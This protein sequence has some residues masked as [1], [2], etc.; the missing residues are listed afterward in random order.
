MVTSVDGLNW[1]KQTAP[2]PYMIYDVTWANNQFVAVGAG[3]MI[4]TS[5]DGVSRSET[6]YGYDTFYG[7]TAKDGVIVIV[8]D[9]EKIIRSQWL[10]LIG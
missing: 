1:T 3:G 6:N 10:C 4:L 2:T 5:S 9:K 8:G 7:V